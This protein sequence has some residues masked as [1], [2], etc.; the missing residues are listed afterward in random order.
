[1]KHVAIALCAALFLPISVAA[2]TNTVTPQGKAFLTYAVQDSVGEISLCEMAEQK[3]SNADVKSFCTKAIADHKNM[4]AQA[5]QLAKQIN[6]TI[7][8]KPS[9]QSVTE[10]A[11]L[12]KKSSSD[13][14]EDFMRGQVQDHRNDIT[15]ARAALESVD[16]AQIKSLAQSSLSTLE[17]HLKLANAT[18]DKLH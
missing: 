16:N 9:A 5:D 4:I 15:A 17:T 18:L 8:Q 6:V 10:K 12:Q 13:F 11:E 3:S 7:K 2:A 1:M 14:D